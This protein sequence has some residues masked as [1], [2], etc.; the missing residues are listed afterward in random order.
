[1]VLAPRMPKWC[2]GDPQ[3]ES[4]NSSSQAPQLDQA[5]LG[6]MEVWRFDFLGGK[7]SPSYHLGL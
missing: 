7:R 5:G 4:T 3:T 6:K 2:A 1:M